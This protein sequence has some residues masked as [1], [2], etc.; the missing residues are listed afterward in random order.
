MKSSV[1]LIRYLSLFLEHSVQP[2]GGLAKEAV[3]PGKGGEERKEVGKL[4]GGF[5]QRPV[6]FDADVESS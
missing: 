4:S 3:S 2:S 5:T 1:Y 6:L